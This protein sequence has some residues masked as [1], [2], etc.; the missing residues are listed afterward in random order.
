MT[1]FKVENDGYE[2]SYIDPPFGFNAP[3]VSVYPVEVTGWHLL[4]GIRKRLGWASFED[5]RILDF[6]CGVRFAKTIANLDMPVGHYCGVDI[7]SGAISWL[8]ENL[9]SS[10]YSFHHL[11]ARNVYYNPEGQDD[12]GADALTRLGISDMDVAIM[13][14]VIT[15][16]TPAEADLTFRQLRNAMAPGGLV[17]FT[18]FVDETKDDYWEQ[19][20]TAPGHMS[21][22]RPGVLMALLENS[23]WRF[24][25]AYEKSTMQQTAFVCEA[26]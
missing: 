20:E 12:L 14:S 17:Y 8:Q 22:Y 9:R 10:R 15:H 24:K 2:F 19:D 1:D 7:H 3:Q 23:G 18:T 4:Q 16:Q 11:N 21:T 13:I 25:T 6:G 5:K 26:V